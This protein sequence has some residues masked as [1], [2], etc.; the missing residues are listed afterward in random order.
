MN[1]D[2]Q[3]S[4]ASPR[5]ALAGR[6]LVV[7]DEPALR[8]L[9]LRAL[10]RPG[11]EV[12]TCADAAAGRQNMLARPADLLI[13]DLHLPGEMDGMSLFRWVKGNFRSTD[14]ILLTGVPTLETAL[15]GFRFGAMDYLLKPVD[16][17]HLRQAA[18]RSLERKRAESELTT[19]KELREAL[20][21]TYRELSAMDGMR[22]TFRRYL[23]KEVADK[24][25]ACPNAAGVKAERRE[26][27]I[28]FADIRR[29]TPFAESR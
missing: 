29:F 23:T 26:V 15:E 11:W 3:K 1:V 8:E 22:E 21:K 13:T 19:E 25:L 10:S 12:V 24:V 14:V 28:L 17:E 4:S 6:I 2:K 5:T 16:L 7:E 18:A 9:F 27:S 20:Q